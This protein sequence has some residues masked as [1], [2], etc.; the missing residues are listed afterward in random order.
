ME[1][2]DLTMLAKWLS[3]LCFLHPSSASC[4][5][6]LFGMG[7]I[8]LNSDSQIFIM[9]SLPI[10]AFSNVLLLLLL[11]LLFKKM[12][13][14]AP[15]SLGSQIWLFS[16]SLAWVLRPNNEIWIPVL[17]F[18]S[19]P[20]Q[21][22]ALSLF[23]YL[24]NGDNQFYPS[25]IALWE[26]DIKAHIQQGTEYHLNF[27]IMALSS[28]VPGKGHSSKVD[29]NSWAAAQHFHRWCVA[30]QETGTRW[31]AGKCTIRHQYP[32]HQFPFIEPYIIRISLG[33]P[34]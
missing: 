30:G 29:Q 13:H 33:S 26:E 11:S 22:L 10:V 32:S 34:Q 20:D 3:E 8:D 14:M 6:L 19:R 4:H 23:P 21:L 9:G 7:V 17:Q 15:N 31:I 2:I 25:T 18:I 5:T 24:G 1:L 12:S 28:L 16:C 27:I